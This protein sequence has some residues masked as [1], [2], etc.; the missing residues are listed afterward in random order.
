MILSD[1]TNP[2]RTKL[3]HVNTLLDIPLQHTILDI[4]RDKL[5][6]VYKLALAKHAH[7]QHLD[8]TSSQTS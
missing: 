2:T 6:Y 1:Y 7:Y 8:I 4:S 3:Q 5:K